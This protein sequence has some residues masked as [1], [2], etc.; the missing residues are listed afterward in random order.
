MPRSRHRRKSPLQAAPQETP[1]D[2]PGS[3][4]EVTPAARQ[5]VEKIL[6]GGPEYAQE[7]LYAAMVASAELAD[8]AEFA[9]WF[10]DAHQYMQV[11]Q[12][13]EAR[14]QRKLKAIPP[15]DE[16]RR[17]ELEDEIHL[18]AVA[19][20]MPPLMR[21]DFHRRLDQLVQRL[22]T[23]TAG[24]KLETALLIQMSSKIKDFPWAM[25]GLVEA[26]RQRSIR[27]EMDSYNRQLSMVRDL[28]DELGPDA[29]NE[30][31]V[32]LLD[33]PARLEA[34]GQKLQADPHL[35]QKMSA[36]AE[37]I[38]ESFYEAL[39]EGKIALPV[40]TQDELQR[41]LLRLMRHLQEE[42]IGLTQEN[43]EEIAGKLVELAKESLREMLT[44]ERWPEVLD[45]L[46]Q[47]E[48]Q[49][50]K[51]FHEFAAPLAL[52]VHDLD[53][54]DPGKAAQDEFLSWLY[55]TQVWKS[56]EPEKEA[57]TSKS[58]PRRRRR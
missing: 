1:Q 52:V 45:S 30:E 12:R 44:P 41:P 39:G 37:A 48:R 6:R 42:G 53:P 11:Y 9:D 13:I 16:S 58:Q 18:E 3:A 49:W 15:Q 55:V 38:L 5:V 22:L 23:T 46:Q 47:I 43:S 35:A 51:E 50:K 36:E 4:G 28:F 40:F 21:R 14:Y 54:L 32:A 2:A 17:Q 24:E 20:M 8:E 56:S 7:H 29:G 26:V 57:G 19:Q 31:I 27:R 34:L 25:C 33:D 10:F